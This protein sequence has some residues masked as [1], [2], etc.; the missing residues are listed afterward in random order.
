MEGLQNI[1]GVIG[2]IQGCIWSCR[3]ILGSTEMY[4]F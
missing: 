3:N 4:G 1:A 2:D